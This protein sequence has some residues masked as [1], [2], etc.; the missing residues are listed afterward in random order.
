MRQREGRGV[1]GHH[2]HG[3][4]DHG[5]G[6]ND[7]G[8]G[9]GPPIY[10]PALGPVLNRAE[11]EI[12]CYPGYPH[13]HSDQTVTEHRQI[14]PAAQMHCNVCSCP[15]GH[16]LRYTLRHSDALRRRQHRARLRVISAADRTSGPLLHTRLQRGLSCRC[17][18]RPTCQKRVPTSRS[19]HTATLVH[20]YRP[21]VRY[22][23]L[24]S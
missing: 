16:A 18:P 21:S 3:R 8:A 13:T 1:Y 14:S 12:L 4:T 7:V 11:I 5:Q 10:S 9:R 23:I 17:R 22:V 15:H 19:S 6:I 20:F 24:L 2:S